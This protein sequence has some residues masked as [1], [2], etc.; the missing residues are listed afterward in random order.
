ME[1]FISNQYGKKLAISKTEEYQTLWMS[2]K[3]GSDKIQF[4]CIFV[5]IS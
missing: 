3:V 1:N 2:D 5:H 4:V